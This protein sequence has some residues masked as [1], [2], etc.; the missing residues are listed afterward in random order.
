MMDTSTQVS[1]H[2]RPLSPT[3]LL[4]PLTPAQF[5]GAKAKA[6]SSNYV[7]LHRNWAGDIQSS[8]GTAHGSGASRQDQSMLQ[9]WQQ[10]PMTQEP[11]HDI[12]KVKKQS[13]SSTGHGSRKVGSG[14][15]SVGYYDPQI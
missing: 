7:D 13:S 10:Q 8:Q 1:V 4:S 3:I 12:G 9:R 2:C 6:D 5:N 11:Y 15:S 14:K